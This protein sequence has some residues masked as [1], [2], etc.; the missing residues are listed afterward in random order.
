MKEKVHIIY[1]KKTSHQDA[2]AIAEELNRPVS[3]VHVS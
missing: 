1:G 2:R 3:A